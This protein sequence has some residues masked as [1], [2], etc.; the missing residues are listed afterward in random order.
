MEI[1]FYDKNTID[2]NKLLYAIVVARY[3]YKWIFVKHKE[4]D[5]WEIP[6]GH[7]EKNED[8]NYTAERELFEETG[9]E[10]FKI[11]YINDYSLKIKEEKSY[12]SLFYAEIYSLGKLPDFEIGEVKEFDDIPQNLTYPN[13]QPDLFKKVKDEI[14]KFVFLEI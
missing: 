13:I 9:A 8:I 5:T 11:T 3:K 10:K 2:N 7:R 6:A 4:R 12:A 14:N 1:E